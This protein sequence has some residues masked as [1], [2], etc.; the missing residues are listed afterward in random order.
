MSGGTIRVWNTGTKL[1]NRG[2]VDNLIDV[3]GRLEGIGTLNG[4]TL[5]IRDGSQLRSIGGVV[6]NPALF[7][8][9]NTDGLYL[10]ALLGSSG[11]IVDVS[12]QRMI[13]AGAYRH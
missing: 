9:S 12:N 13:V 10:N 1:L 5:T 3:S 6:T 2:I 7:G 4:S 11:G 8:G